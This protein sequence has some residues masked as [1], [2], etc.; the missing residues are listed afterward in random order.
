MNKQEI[1]S[2]LSALVATAEKFRNAYF[3]SSPQ[4]AADRRNYE[5]YHSIPEF[6]FEYDGKSYTAE[7]SV[8]CTCNNVYAR[9]YYYRDGKKTNITTLKNV[10]QKIQAEIIKEA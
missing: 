4:K 9:G 8:Q 7:Y 6:A 3:W 1:L 10:M 5:K 2:A